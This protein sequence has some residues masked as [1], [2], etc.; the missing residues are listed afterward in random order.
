M[1]IVGYGIEALGAV[2][3]NGQ[4]LGVTPSGLQKP[5][6]A[7]ESHCLCTLPEFET[8]K[9]MLCTFGLRYGSSAVRGDP[10]GGLFGEN[11]THRKTQVG[12][13]SYCTPRGSVK[14]L[15]SL[16]MSRPL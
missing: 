10:A 14:T 9:G 12:I 16:L 6:L 2:E 3:S 11:T 15:V 1:E 13:V 4:A 8:V 5:R 7:I